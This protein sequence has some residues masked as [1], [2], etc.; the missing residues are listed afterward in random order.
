MSVRTEERK[1]ESSLTACTTTARLEPI[2]RCLSAFYHY[3]GVNETYPMMLLG[4]LRD[5]TSSVNEK[6]AVP[7][8]SLAMFPRSPTCLTES[9]RAP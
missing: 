7:C 6:V 1:A 9:V 2:M 4:P 3:P 8:S 5:I